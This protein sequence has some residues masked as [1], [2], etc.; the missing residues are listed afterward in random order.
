M[1]AEHQPKWRLILIFGTLVAVATWFVVL[2]AGGAQL[3]E[4]VPSL[5]KLGA[6]SLV[7]WVVWL[8]FTKLAWRWS[9]LRWNHWLV[10][11]PDLNGRWVGKYVSMFDKQ[12]RRMVLEIRQTFLRVQ[13]VA[14]GPDSVG[15]SYVARLL[16]DG[17]E[18]GFKFVYFYHAKRKPTTSNPGDEHEGIAVLRVIAG[19][20]RRLEGYYVNDR[21]P[22]PH[23][24]DIE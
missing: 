18:H 20:C 3:S 8:L 21:H 24:G 23:K 7:V 14:F 16:S 12:E 11:T 1:F 13:C 9:W 5:T 15:E 6:V 22:A 19:A 10:S 4:L 17:D 2:L